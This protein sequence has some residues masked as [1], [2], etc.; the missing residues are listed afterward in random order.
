MNETE[1]NNY[2]QQL[3]ELAQQKAAPS[4]RYGQLLMN[5]LFEFDRASYDLITG[6]E[7]D[8]FYLEHKL[9]AFIA[10]LREIKMVN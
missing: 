4:M 10:K 3:A 5:A 1:F 8:C 9:S 7:A 6:T 2:F